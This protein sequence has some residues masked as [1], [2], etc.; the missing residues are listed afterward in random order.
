M[1]LNYSCVN[2]QSFVRLVIK[3]NRCDGFRSDAADPVI[4]IMDIRRKN[5]TLISL[6]QGPCMMMMTTTEER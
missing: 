3:I 2:A 6:L 4:V 5:E 1:I